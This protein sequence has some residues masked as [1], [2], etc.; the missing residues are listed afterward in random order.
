VDADGDGMLDSRIFELK[1]TIIANNTASFKDVL[2]LPGPYRWFFG[3]RCVD[4][5]GRVNVNT[6]TDLA[7]AP[8]LPT[9]A[10]ANQPLLRLG[11]SPAEVDLLRVLRQSDLISDAELLG[12]LGGA[13]YYSGPMVSDAPDVAADPIAAYTQ[14]TGAYIATRMALA[15]GLIPALKSYDDST[16]FAMDGINVGDADPLQ[17]FWVSTSPVLPTGW[18]VSAYP[19]VS[20]VG[21]FALN[22]TLT[23]A[24]DYERRVRLQHEISSQLGAGGFQSVL[25][26]GFGEDDLA[27]LLERE[28]I[29]SPEVS[30]LER[31]MAGRDA[32]NVLRSSPLRSARTLEE[33]M[34][35]QGRRYDIVQE[36]DNAAPAAG[37]PVPG[38]DTALLMSAY[39]PRRCLTTL[40]G[41]RPLRSTGGTRRIDL[42][43]VTVT[44]QS[45]DPYELD[46]GEPTELTRG[47]LTLDLR[48]A[49]EQVYTT[50]DHKLRNQALS[51]IYG[52][53]ADALAPYSNMPDA[54]GVDFTSPVAEL[55]TLFYGHRGPELAMQTAAHM[56][57]NL[58][59]ML[60]EDTRP[61]GA[62][63]ALTSDTGVRNFLNTN[64]TGPTANRFY[65]WWNENNT[66]T[67]RPNVPPTS[68]TPNEPRHS[69]WGVRLSI[70]NERLAPTIDQTAV[71][72]MNVYGVEPQPFLTQVV[73]MTAYMDTRTGT[74]PNAGSDDPPG[75]Y[76]IKGNI[77]VAGTAFDTLADNEDLLFRMVAFTITNPFDRPLRLSPAWLSDAMNAAGA[78]TELVNGAGAP[79]EPGQYL[80]VTT[81][82]SMARVDTMDD[83]HYLQWGDKLY[84]LG[85]LE[86]KAATGG[87]PT[88]DMIPIYP[89]TQGQYVPDADTGSNDFVTLGPLD[90]GANRSV[91]CYAISH[92]P[93]EVFRR[94]RDNG[95]F[96]TAPTDEAEA[97][98]QV[99]ATHLAGVVNNPSELIWIPMIGNETSGP[100]APLL[101]RLVVPDE[102]VYDPI[103]TNTP[104]ALANAAGAGQTVNLW[105]SVRVGD[106][107]DVSAGSTVSL[108]G[109]SWWG[110]A[111]TP[112][113]AALGP[114]QLTVR[115]PND[116]ANDQLVD[117]MRLAAPSAGSVDPLSFMSL[118]MVDGEIDVIGSDAFFDPVDPDHYA[119]TMWAYCTRRND[120]RRQAAPFPAPA[121]TPGERPLPDDVLPAYC[122]EPKYF[123][124]GSP[125]NIARESPKNATAILDTLNQSD[126]QGS[127]TVG[128]ADGA[129]AWHGHMTNVDPPIFD[130]EEISLPPQ[131]RYTL[132]R[133]IDEPG[134]VNPTLALGGAEV[135]GYDQLY[136]QI[137]SA[138]PALASIGQARAIDSM[139][140][141]DVLLPLGIGPM[142]TPYDSS[143]WGGT[144]YSNADFDPSDAPVDR[145]FNRR[146]TTLGEAVAIALG[147]EEPATALPTANLDPALW[148]AYDTQ[149]PANPD[150]VAD[151]EFVF[152]RGNLRLG[153]F[154]P[155]VDIDG[156]G[157]FTPDQDDRPVGALPGA[158]AVLDQFHLGPAYDNPATPALDSARIEPGPSLTQLRPG[159]ININ[160]A[161]RAV[162]GA[163]PMAAPPDIANTIGSVGGAAVASVEN[164]W[165]GGAGSPFSGPAS[166]PVTPPDARFDLVATMLAYRDKRDV[167]PR[168]ATDNVLAG[169][170]GPG[171]P[172]LGLDQDPVADNPA[173][174]LRGDYTGINGL[175]DLVGFKGVGEL[176]AVR[177]RNTAAPNDINYRRAPFNIDAMGVD[178]TPAGVPVQS[179]VAAID[180]FS[181]TP[182]ATS[183]TPPTFVANE[184][185]EKLAIP[186]A[187]LG[188][189]TTRSDVFALWFV[190]MG[191][192]PSDIDAVQDTTDPL[193]PS[194]QRRFLMVIDRSNVTKLDQKPRIVLFK[195]VPL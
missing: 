129:P 36:P 39:D 168:V 55:S 157:V 128:W 119:L 6:A 78:P 109:V 124:P 111:S 177:E 134:F 74:N 154:A 148:Y 170:F 70:E 85:K 117:R 49:V 25:L 14:G 68:P 24:R 15:S 86:R 102:V 160:T 178:V 180:T 184:F 113:P 75:R 2:A 26:G 132:N 67:V 18:M 182:T 152:D 191:F 89:G 50:N 145:G 174:I 31:A 143:N 115:K 22:S 137:N 60:D 44:T 83:Y 147:Y 46:G 72:A 118:K 35:P 175:T 23:R 52:A 189:V 93:R 136:P 161:S 131:Y 53:Y 73:T 186:G 76:A 158:M 105:R 17:A 65:P 21:Q 190:V 153:G 90:V 135:R 181:A 56:T 82:N 81:I 11:S 37:L 122:I 98:R 146:W 96:P 155:F 149:P 61:T 63:F 106:E 121:L 116:L 8:A 172:R 4:L 5:S 110:G 7:S 107:D 179:T 130:S 28:G 91:V 32:A 19:Q 141:V 42:D 126:F 112:A 162:L 171:T 34:G 59:D 57:V 62:S 1:D 54:W 69:A 103:P 192:Q 20:D 40:S 120:I 27:E 12:S 133:R 16:T 108:G 51:A 165:A 94:L 43:G 87:V 66:F 187:M 139:R 173:D 159:L 188:S 95:A 125:W 13:T 29:N 194:V 127:V 114:P 166:D 33:E 9:G 195:E 64:S 3:A 163:L 167:L 71:P 104:T 193:V 176:L 38:R 88:D 10:A 48:T 30:A 150:T 41:S 140:L 47:E 58:A 183:A 100:L 79:D 151:E 45:I 164:W 169:T 142:Q 92:S 101:G 144:P 77:P 156:D 99:L 123:D 97:I 138:R 84:L 185:D 80:S